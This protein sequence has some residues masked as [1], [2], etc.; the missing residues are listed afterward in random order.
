MSSVTQRLSVMMFLQFFVWGAWFATLGLA[1]G[2]NGLA[3]IIGQ[4]YG[5]API[6]AI[7]APLFLGLIADRFFA[8]ERVMA[9]L[10]LIGG[11]LLCLAAKTAAA[12]NGGMTVWLFIGH[13]LC[14]MPTLGLSNTIAFTNIGDQNEFPKIRVWGTIGWIVAGLLVG[15]LGWSSSFNIFWLG[16]LSSIV[17]GLYSFSLPHTPPPA[18]DKPFDIRSLLMFDAFSLLGK[19]PF[20]V[21][22]TCSTLICIPLAYYYGNTAM[23][24]DNTGFT[25][26]ASSMTIGQMSEI[27]FMLLIPFFFRR[28]G[29]KNMILI[30]MACWVLRYLLF[31]VGAPNQVAWMLY[32]GIALHGICYDFFFVTGFMYT[33]KVADASIRGQAQGMLVF[34]TQGIGM[35]FGYW[36][37]DL[38]HKRTVTGY[39]DLTKAIA[40]SRPK[41]TPS[42][43]Q[44]LLNMFSVDKL[45]VDAG[46]LSETMAQWKS[47]WLLPAGMAAVITAIFFLG[48]WDK[49]SNH[50]KEAIDEGSAG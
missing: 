18:K 2:S 35:Y 4:A 9:V 32:L 14:Y 48:F 41:T 22:I 26:P 28:L 3:D 34:F 25:A 39:G 40:D 30:G 38:L 7:L 31:A 20:L 6:A 5:S 12:G 37:A 10:F 33:D 42:F 15:V 11:V 16:G 46:L 17:M 36:V 47:F 23:Y 29:V 43:V 24:L 19:L 27:F 8:S 1:L 50:D 13:M 21:F 45:N 49:M 44:S